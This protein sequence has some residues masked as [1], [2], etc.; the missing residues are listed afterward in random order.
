MTSDEKNLLNEHQKILPYKFSLIVL[1]I[2]NAN[3]LLYANNTLL[4]VE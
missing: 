4:T 1:I 2:T 3:T